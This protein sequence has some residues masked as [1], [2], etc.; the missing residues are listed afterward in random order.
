MT[1]SVTGDAG[2]MLALQRNL[3]KFGIME[4]ART[5]KICLKRGGQLLEMGGW[6]DSS[7]RRASLLRKQV[8]NTFRFAGRSLKV[9]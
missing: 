2:K 9:L 3:A 7:T 1:L 8:C 6:G 5:G 4:I